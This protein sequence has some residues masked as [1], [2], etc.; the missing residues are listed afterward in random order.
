MDRIFFF[1]YLYGN[2]ISSNKSISHYDKLNFNNSIEVKYIKDS[3]IRKN[4]I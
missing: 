2:Q 4:V 1:V 3:E